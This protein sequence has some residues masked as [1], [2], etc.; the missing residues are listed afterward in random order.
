MR[1]ISSVA[2]ITL[3]TALLVTG[4]SAGS[5]NTSRGVAIGQPLPHAEFTT[6]RGERVSVADLRGNPAVINFWA[7]WCAP[8][9]EEIP[10]LQ[11]AHAAYGQK[12]V[13]FLAV[14]DELPTTVRP[15]MEQINMTLPVWYDPGGRA[16]QRY[17]I[18]SIP[19]T[20]FLDAEGRLVARHI[21][22][23]TRRQLEAYLQ[24]LMAERQEQRETPP[25]DPPLP[26]RIPAPGGADTVGWRRA[27]PS[28][29]W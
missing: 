11:A 12:G 17:A 16:G 22:A 19:T 8:C 28:A 5:G 15:F 10:V 6:G 4:C 7:T 14:T 27:E 26:T 13:A 9:R 29:T 23:L 18:Q 1:P 25:G 3:M 20:F 24:Q 21:G 2:L